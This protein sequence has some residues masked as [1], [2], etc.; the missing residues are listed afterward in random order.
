M[1]CGHWPGRLEVVR[2]DQVQLECSGERLDLRAHPLEIEG[3]QIFR[4]RLASAADRP[5]EERDIVLAREGLVPRPAAAA[6]QEQPPA[7]AT[8]LRAADHRDEVAPA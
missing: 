1:R 6:A 3:S 7:L 2:A 5:H 8:G 4:D